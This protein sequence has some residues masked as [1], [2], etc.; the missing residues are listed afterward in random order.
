MA[1]SFIKWDKP[2]SKVLGKGYAFSS[3]KSERANSS[4]DSQSNTSAYSDF[5]N[6]K[7]NSEISSNPFDHVTWFEDGQLNVCH[8]V[9]D[10]H[11]I[12]HPD[13]IAIIWE[14]DEPNTGYSLT[15]QEL[16]EQVC[17]LSNL[18]TRKF[19]YLKP[20][21]DVVTIYMS[22]VP[23]AIIAMLACARVGLIH[24]FFVLYFPL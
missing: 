2:F 9:L 3:D 8:N 4:F 24:K 12:S 11:A 18:L 13:K 23:Q 16:L 22:M 6:L 10:I 7:F 14:A 1:Q 21:K 19:S 5:E 17:Q 15:Y 20:G